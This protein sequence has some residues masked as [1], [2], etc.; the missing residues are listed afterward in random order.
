MDDRSVLLERMPAPRWYGKRSGK[1]FYDYSKEYYTSRSRGHSPCW[2]R[3][4]LPVSSM[5]YYTDNNLQLHLLSLH[6][7]IAPSLI[8][9]PCAVRESSCGPGVSMSVAGITH[10]SQRGKLIIQV[11]RT[12]STNAHFDEHWI[13]LSISFH[14]S[15]VLIASTQGAPNT[16]F[17]TMQVH[18][19]VCTKDVRG[20]PVKRCATIKARV[21]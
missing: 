14:A 21:M 8:D 18:K 13:T 15:L 3:C 1:G 17:V 19:T 5:N 9:F 11:I 12:L 7:R 20:A 10:G 4:P 6:G 16:C 2:P